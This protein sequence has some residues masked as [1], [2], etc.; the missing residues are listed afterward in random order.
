MPSPLKS[1][2]WEREVGDV[3]GGQAEGEQGNTG[4]G[5]GMETGGEQ[6]QHAHIALLSL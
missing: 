6:P 4:N 1:L 2:M 5:N 3:Y